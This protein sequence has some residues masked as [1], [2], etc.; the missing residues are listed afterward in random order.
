MDDVKG[1]LG[2]LGAKGWSF[3]SVGD[4]LR[5]PA[6]TVRKLSGGL[7]RPADEPIVIDAIRR[8]VDRKRV[9]NSEGIR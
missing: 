6:N 2:V 7:R 8:L 3:V 9:R 5:I 4:A 1:T